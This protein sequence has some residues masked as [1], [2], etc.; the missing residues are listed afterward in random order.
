VGSDRVA[1]SVSVA[2]SRVKVSEGDSVAVT[3]REGL[4]E[5]VGRARVGVLVLD[6]ST[7]EMLGLFEADAVFAKEIVSV[8]LFD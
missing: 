8:A 3:V 2:V 6:G 5:A 4:E 7:T 1:E